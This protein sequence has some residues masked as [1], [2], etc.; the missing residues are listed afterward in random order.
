[1]GKKLAITF[2]PELD[3]KTKNYLIDINVKAGEALEAGEILY[4]T[5]CMTWTNCGASSAERIN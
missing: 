3:G 4:T 2:A 1:M 5:G